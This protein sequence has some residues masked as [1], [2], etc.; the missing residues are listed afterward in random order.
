MATQVTLLHLNQ[1]DLTRYDALIIGNMV[2]DNFPGASQKTPFFNQQVY[3]ELGLPS[4]QKQQE[5]KYFYF[6][7]LLD[8]ADNIMLSYHKGEQEA[9]VSPW[10]ELLRNF[11]T[12][13]FDD[14]LS[15]P[16]LHELVQT[17]Y[18]IQRP[19]NNSLAP[20]DIKIDKRK[21]PRRMSASAHQTLINCPYAYFL[22][23]VLRL[24]APEE[25]RM[26]LAKNDYGERIHYIL[27]AFH[28]GTTERLP[29]PFTERVTDHNRSEAIERLEEISRVVFHSDLEDNFQ[30]RG[31]FKRWLRTIPLYIDWLIADQANW[32]FAQGE[33]SASNPLDNDLTLYGRIDRLDKAGQS[34]GRILD[35]K[36]G[37]PPHK[38]DVENG[39]SVQFVHYALATDKKA[40]SLGYLALESNGKPIKA[41]IILD[42]DDNLPSIL[43][44][45]AQRLRKVKQQ[46]D[47]QTPMV[48]WGDETTCHFCQF[49]GVCRTRLD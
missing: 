9:Q 20:V 37:R 42:D 49:S 11:H 2:R 28:Q 26:T 14:D 7:R 44:T 31:W 25:I 21:R 10:L 30:H 3:Y 45:A 24:R 48:A 16:V 6:R 47:T 38:N 41:N 22:A 15:D 13:A 34:H 17:N 12:L 8:S 29:P 36:T 33:I 43:D 35:Y 23:E 40:D 4:S 18:H 39:E 27:F 1:S 5:E 46:I 19:T 32:T